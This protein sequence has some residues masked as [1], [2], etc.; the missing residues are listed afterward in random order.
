MKEAKAATADKKIDTVTFVWMQGEKDHQ[1]DATTQAYRKNLETLYDQL[2][3]DFKRDDI[4]WVIGRLSDA[5]LGTANWD[6]IRQIQVDVTDK[7]PRAA[8]IDTDDLNGPDDG[9]HCPP[10]GY[11]QMGIRFAEKAVG[12]I[13]QSSAPRPETAVPEGTN[14]R[15]IP[16]AKPLDSKDGFAQWM[17]PNQYTAQDILEMIDVLKPQVLERFITGKQNVKAMVPVRSGHQP[18]TVGQFL[19]DS[20]NTGAPGCVIV[21]KLNLTWISWGREKYFW[22]TAENYFNLPLSRPIRIVNL[23]NW[24]AFLEKHGEQKA[25]ELLKRLKEVGYESIGVNM[26]GGFN[27]GYGY[28]SFGDFLIDSHTWQLRLSTLNKMKNDPR[29]SQYYLYIDYPG[30]MDEF[31]KLTV[32]QQA[33]VFTKVIRASEKTHGFTFVYPVLFD[34]WDATKRLT[35]KAGEYR[36]HR[37]LKSFNNQSRPASTAQTQHRLKET[38]S[39]TANRC[40]L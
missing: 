10:K 36:G 16:L 21:P 29:L 15:I 24:N 14:V 17:F 33:D 22:E 30:Q 18:M 11:K 34:Q 40:R 12:L 35:S 38:L 37:C 20:I 6:A 13:K 1:E 8:W 25:T 27:E 39:Y 2:T 23:D 3:E 31:M 26:A 28:L 7:H 32:D 4:N 19:N 5:R 9:V